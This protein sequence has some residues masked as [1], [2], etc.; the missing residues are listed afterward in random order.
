M[1]IRDRVQVAL[2]GHEALRRLKVGR[3]LSVEQV[4]PTVLNG[5]TV[6]A[7]AV[8]RRTV[9]HEAVRLALLIRGDE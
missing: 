8:A 6:Q 7:D 9:N 5:L 4:A 1:C 2:V 3:L